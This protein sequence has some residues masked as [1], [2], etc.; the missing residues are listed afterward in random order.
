MCIFDWWELVLC[1]QS[2]CILTGGYFELSSGPGP[3]A[4]A[5]A[6]AIFVRDI[7]EGASQSPLYSEE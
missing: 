7:D 6:R 1:F 3:G 4:R 5:R 2:V